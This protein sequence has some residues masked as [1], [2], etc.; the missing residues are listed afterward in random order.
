MKTLSVHEAKTQLSAVLA[1]IEATGDS[2]L[3]CRHGKPV[4]ENRVREILAGGNL[5]PAVRVP[6]AKPFVS[7]FTATVRGGSPPS[8]TLEMLGNQSGRGNTI[9]YA[10][11]EAVAFFPPSIRICRGFD[12]SLFGSSISSN[13]LW[14]VAWILL[15]SITPGS[16][17]NSCNTP[18]KR[19]AVM[20]AP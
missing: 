11:I 10:A 6:F 17:E 1:E 13:P 14:N 16:V 15:R 3:V 8:R 7:Y 5:S 12:S 4:A 19:T 2:F 9:S 18:S 20:A